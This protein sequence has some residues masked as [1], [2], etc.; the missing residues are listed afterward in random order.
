MDCAAPT[1]RRR[2]YR[3]AKCRGRPCYYIIYAE[4][5]LQLLLLQCSRSL[6]PPGN[7][8]DD[9]DGLLFIYLYFNFFFSPSPCPVRVY[10]ISVYKLPAHTEG[11]VYL[12]TRNKLRPRDLKTS[13]VSMCVCEYLGTLIDIGPSGGEENA[14]GRQ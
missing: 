11:Y 14:S 1:I 4:Q 6:S 8:D 9:D 12:Y 5:Q 2:R 13:C 7:R 3:S 10:N